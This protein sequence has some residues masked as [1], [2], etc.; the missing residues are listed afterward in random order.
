VNEP[1]TL[2]PPILAKVEDQLDRLEHLI[3][4]IPPDRLRW[5]PGFDMFRFGDLLGHLLECLAGFCA[6]L[7]AAQPERLARLADL[8][9]L[10]VN[11]YCEVDEALARIAQ[12]QTHIRQG[13]TVLSDSDLSKRIPT[14]FKQ[15]GETVLTLLLTNLEHLIS[16]KQQLFLYLRLAG[17]QAG[18][19]DLYRFSG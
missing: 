19:K 8:R 2:P 9:T 10:K 12:Y 14:V 13:F 4:L 16:H 7:Y 1:R 15:E 6:T 11:H 18:T 5:S 17:V 3:R